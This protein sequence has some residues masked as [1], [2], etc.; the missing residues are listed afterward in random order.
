MRFI[1]V[2]SVPSGNSLILSLSGKKLFF[3]QMLYSISFAIYPCI[4]HVHNLKNGRV[5]EQTNRERKKEIIIK[6]ERIGEK[7][8]KS[9]Y[10]Y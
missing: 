8:K 5:A 9:I 1:M 3:L 2:F 6:W 7:I 4:Q 10:K